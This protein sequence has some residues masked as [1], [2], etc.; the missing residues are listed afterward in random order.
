MR[1]SKQ[2]LTALISTLAVVGLVGCASPKEVRDLTRETSRNIGQ[3]SKALRNFEENSDSIQ[4]LLA[5]KIDGVDKRVIE[6]ELLLRESVTVWKLSGSRH[7]ERFLNEMSLLAEIISEAQ[8][9]NSPAAAKR[10]KQA[11]LGTLEV[12]KPPT[13]EMKAVQEK[14]AE[15]LK[16]DE[17]FGKRL[18]ALWEYSK[19]VAEEVKAAEKE[20]AGDS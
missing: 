16:R 11:I 9:V 12:S 8:T 5:R 13:A 4:N 14:I 17:S 18:K 2:Q 20:G 6:S 7:K 1:N 10:R 3:V 19:D 15:L